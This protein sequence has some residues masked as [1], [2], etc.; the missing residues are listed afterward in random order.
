MEGHFVAST[1]KVSD[2]IQFV[3]ETLK[4]KDIPFVLSMN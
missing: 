3:R 1:H 2:L 4:D